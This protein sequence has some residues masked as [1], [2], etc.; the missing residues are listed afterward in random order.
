MGAPADRVVT[1]KDVARAAGVHASTA[2]RALD[3]SKSGC[4]SPA[5]VER[6][7]R[8][9][10]QLGYVPDMI[11]KGLR[12]GTTS[13][14]GVVVA[15]LENPFFGPVVRG[16]S[17][18]LESRGFVTLVAETLEDRDRFERTLNHLLSRRVDA[19]VTTAA[20]S[21]DAELLDRFAG[22]IPACV[23]AVRNIEGSG[24]PY[25]NQDDRQ[26]GGM[27]ADHL[28]ELGHASLA[29][30]RGPVDIDTFANRAEGFRRS[31]GD[32]GLVDA[33]VGEQGEALTL[34]EG[35]RLMALTLDENPARAPTAI[36]A[37]ADVMAI[38][39]IEEMEAR[40]LR[41]PE[42]ISVIGYDDAPLVSHIQPPLSTIE[43]PGL[44]LGGRAGEMV[45]EMIDDPGSVPESVSLPARLVARES[46]AAP[47][48]RGG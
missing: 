47:P 10:T 5:T 30:L 28:I 40:G 37:H 26:G 15:D 9:A 14:V 19:L 22:R 43:L 21:G 7:G 48:K 33:T 1:L 35:R 41:C 24:L 44:E 23:L 27:A 13:M 36:F 12:G 4:I 46:T 45:L 11:A 16:I 31:V 39:A 17:K 42:D 34:E 8:A 32:A 38:G 29:Q 20:R 3:P 2:S 25:V 6:V 18:Q